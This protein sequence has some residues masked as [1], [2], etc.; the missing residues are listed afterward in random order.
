ME[1]VRQLSNK[2]RDFKDLVC[3]VYFLFVCSFVPNIMKKH[4]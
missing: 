3:P 4:G 2:W 1:H